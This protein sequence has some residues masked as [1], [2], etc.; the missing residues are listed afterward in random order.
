MDKFNINVVE[1]NDFGDSIEKTTTI[2]KKSKK[3]ISPEEIRKISE[4]LL[5]NAPKGSKIRIRGLGIDR[6]NTLQSYD[7]ALQILDYEEYYE[8]KVKE[9]NKFADFSQIEITL[10]KIK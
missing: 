7:K 3:R 4:K 8:G 1:T 10:L 6:W 5:K 2:S 9:P